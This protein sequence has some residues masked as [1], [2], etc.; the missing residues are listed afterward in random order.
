MLARATEWR[1]IECALLLN[2]DAVIDTRI[3]GKLESNS[4]CARGGASPARWRVL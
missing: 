4:N 1:K 2:T 3:L